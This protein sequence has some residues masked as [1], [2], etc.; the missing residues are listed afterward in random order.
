LRRSIVL[1]HSFDAYE[2]ARGRAFTTEETNVA[3]AASLWPTLHNA[4]GE[5]LY[6]QPPV[7]LTAL[8]EQV[9]VRLALARA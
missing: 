7:A 1:T 4:R 2:E 9:D 5:V 3:W 6:E 8:E